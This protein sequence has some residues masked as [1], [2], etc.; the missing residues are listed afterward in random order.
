MISQPSVIFQHK[1]YNLLLFS[2]FSEGEDPHVPPPLFSTAMV[3][4]YLFRNRHRK[5]WRPYSQAGKRHSPHII[6]T[7][8]KPTK[9]TIT[10]TIINRPIK[11]RPEFDRSSRKI[12]EVPNRDFHTAPN[13][14]PNGRL[15]RRRGEELRVCSHGESRDSCSPVREICFTS[16]NSGPRGPEGGWGGG[17]E[18]GGE[19]ARRFLE[20]L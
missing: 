3:L 16:A 19:S 15:N 2:K 12:P 13:R 1:S 20:T 18:E 8:L 17:S 10:S 7:I 5:S 9:S 11:K 14:I 4:N 6:Q